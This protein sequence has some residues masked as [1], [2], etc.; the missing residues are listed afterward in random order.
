MPCN[1]FSTLDNLA[2][3]LTAQSFCGASRMRAPFA[4]PRLSEPRKV[5][6]DA[7]AVDTN[8]EIVSPDARILALSAVDVVV[9]DQ[10]MVDG[11]DGILPEQLFGRNLGAEVAC[12]RSHVAVRELE[13]SARKGVRELIRDAP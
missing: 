4:P 12:P 10:L 13:P 8:S 7:H 6:A 9:I 1:D 2:G 3:S 11:R 5:D